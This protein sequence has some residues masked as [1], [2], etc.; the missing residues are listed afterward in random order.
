MIVHNKNRYSIDVPV[1]SYSRKSGKFPTADFM[2]LLPGNN[3]VHVDKWKLAISQVGNDRMSNMGISVIAPTGKTEKV[4]S[5]SR[6]GAEQIVEIGL[7]KIDV[8]EL[9]GVNLDLF[10]KGINTIEIAKHSLS[11]EKA[12]PA[13]KRNLIVELLEKKVKD[14]TKMDKLIQENT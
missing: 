1:S 8:T 5:V 3:Q 2:S 10:V 11:L 12:R 9:S 14:I 13:G 6:G 7:D 4:K